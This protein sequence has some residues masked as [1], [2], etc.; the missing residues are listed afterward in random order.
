MDSR[1]QELNRIDNLLNV[2]IIKIIVENELNQSE[3]YG[4]FATSA[5]RIIE[6]FQLWIRQEFQVDDEKF[7]LWMRDNA[8]RI[9]TEDTKYFENKRRRINIEINRLAK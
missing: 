2:E 7:Q 6:E 9:M 4:S 8:S 1:E 5:H 3:K